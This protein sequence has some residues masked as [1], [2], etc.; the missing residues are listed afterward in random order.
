MGTETTAQD[1]DV[2]VIGS[3]FGG[4]VSAL[5]MAEKGY[6]VLVVEQGRE[7]S[8]DDLAA[9]GQDAKRLLY[10]PRLGL[11]KGFF[12]QELYRHVSLVRGIGVGGGSLRAFL[13]RARLIAEQLRHSRMVDRRALADDRGRCHALLVGASRV[14]RQLIVSHRCSLARLGR[15]VNPSPSA[16]A[17]ALRRE[18]PLAPRLAGIGAGELVNRRRCPVRPA[19]AAALRS[20]EAD[21]RGFP[22]GDIN[23][24]TP[25]SLIPDLEVVSLD[26]QVDKLRQRGRHVSVAWVAV[27]HVLPLGEKTSDLGVTRADGSS[28]GCS[29]EHASRVAHHRHDVNRADPRRTTHRRRHRRRGTLR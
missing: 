1:W 12:A 3:G 20:R 7:V 22:R 14:E 19:V 28:D 21:A 26:A 16:H 29:V 17:P 24:D 11:R 9:A 5:R 10:Q 25:T 27:G 15:L 4:A 23:A 13:R 6:R 18:V 2:V 8:A